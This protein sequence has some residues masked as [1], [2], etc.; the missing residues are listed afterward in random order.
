MSATISVLIDELLD[1][2]KCGGISTST[3][4]LVAG[5]GNYTLAQVHRAILFILDDFARETRATRQIDSLTLTA[6][7]STVSFTGLAGF[8]PDRIVGSGIRVVAD[9]NYSA[10]DCDVARGIQVV[11]PE[12]VADAILACGTGTGTPTLLT[13]DT[14]SA[15]FPSAAT[16]WRT[17]KATGTAKVEWSPPFRTYNATVLATIT[18]GATDV[19]AYT[20]N[21]RDEM[22]KKA[23][24]TGGVVALQ[25]Y[26]PQ[27]KPI[28]DPLKQEYDAHV[29]ASRGR[30]NLGIRSIQRESV[31]DRRWR[32]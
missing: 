11:G 27:K 9:S 5:S 7:S 8:D 24:R 6:D 14:F 21:I 18:P 17:P 13:F 26:E 28:T 15:G 16:V 23:V 1:A 22:A 19:G 32:R 10:T 20:T 31:S 30:G 3:T 4:T 12:K 25:R 29:A 2:A